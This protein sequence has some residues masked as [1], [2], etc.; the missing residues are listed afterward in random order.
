MFPKEI[1]YF[2]IYYSVI[3]RNMDKVTYVLKMFANVELFFSRRRAID[4]SKFSSIDSA[5]HV[6]TTTLL[7]Y[8]WIY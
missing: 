7:I 4:N 6:C 5:I 2:D 1:I 3:V 8:L